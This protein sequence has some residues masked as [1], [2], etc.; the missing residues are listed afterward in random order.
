MT[1]TFA[2]AAQQL[3]QDKHQLAVWF[4]VA[5]FLKGLI[6]NDGTD[7]AAGIKAEGCI[8]KIV[9]QSLIQDVVN[10]IEKEHIDSLTESIQAL[11]NFQV[12]EANDEEEGDKKQ[13][14]IKGRRPTVQ[15]PGVQKGPV[16]G[17]RGPR[18]AVRSI[19]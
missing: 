18:S 10:Y 17:V 5:G 11:E 12:L 2:E 8:Q 9:P 1:M 16:P 15:K 7:A 3:E 19:G 13:K 6:S 14:S 4:E